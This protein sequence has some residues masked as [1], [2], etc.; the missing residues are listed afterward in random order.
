MDHP[1]IK[2]TDSVDQQMARVDAIP[3][4]T[5]TLGTLGTSLYADG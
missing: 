1:G 5:E 4:A 3:Q 2:I